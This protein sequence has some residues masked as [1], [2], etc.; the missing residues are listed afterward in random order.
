MAKLIVLARARVSRLTAPNNSLR[1]HVV[2]VVAAR[3]RLPELRHVADMGGEA[4]LDLAVVGR[5]HDEARLGDE[6]V[7]DAAADLGADRDVHEVGIGRGE[8]PGLR[9]RQASSWCG[10]GRSPC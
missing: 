10:P 2:D 7:A 5:E 3:E 4:Q 1:G 6:G 9:A 8:P